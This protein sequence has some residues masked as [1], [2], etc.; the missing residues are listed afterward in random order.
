[1]IIVELNALRTKLRE[2]G[3]SW[4]ILR[5]QSG[6]AELAVRKADP[7]GTCCRVFI[8]MMTISGNASA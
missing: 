5:I 2:K 8:E 7:H 1:M 3:I 4:W 6:I